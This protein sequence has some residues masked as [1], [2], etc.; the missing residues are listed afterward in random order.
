M[1]RHL[2]AFLSV[3]SLGLVLSIYYVLIPRDVPKEVNNT[4][5]SIDVSESEDHYFASLKLQREEEHKDK[6]DSFQMIM[7]STNASAEEKKSALERIEA[8][9]RVYSLE[10]EIDNK[11]TDLGYPNAY[12]RIVDKD[13][14]LVIGKNDKEEPNEV[15][16][17]YLVLVELNDPSFDIAL[18]FR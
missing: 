6:I 7:V 13:V 3:F 11:I 18:S 4:F 2:I 9:N 14:S 12:T 10:L 8:E 17:L 15:K 5:D 1:N 16:I